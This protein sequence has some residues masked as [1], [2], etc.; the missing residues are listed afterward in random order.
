MTLKHPPQ[1]F[2][3]RTMLARFPPDKKEDRG[4]ALVEEARGKIVVCTGGSSVKTP[5]VGHGL[6][7]SLIIPIKE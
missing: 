5:P 2:T 6:S 4:G 7:A 3:Q 1:L